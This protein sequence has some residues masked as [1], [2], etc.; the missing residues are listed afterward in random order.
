MRPPR[1]RLSGWEAVQV[2]RAPHNINFSPSHQQQHERS[3][4]QRWHKV[5]T[6]A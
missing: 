3:R 5:F 4:P 1:K 2:G 6:V